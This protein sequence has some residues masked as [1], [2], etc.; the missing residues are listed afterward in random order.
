LRKAKEREVGPFIATNSPTLDSAAPDRGAQ[1]KR[2]ERVPDLYLFLTP[3][4][5][6]LSGSRRVKFVPEPRHRHSLKPSMAFH[7]YLFGFGVDGKH[8]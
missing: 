4:I 7:S 5:I 3:V 1:K 8:F 6:L 2:P